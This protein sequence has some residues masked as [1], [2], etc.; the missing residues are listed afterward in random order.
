MHSL[1]AFHNPSSRIFMIREVGVE[2]SKCK[3]KWVDVLIEVWRNNE[4][5]QHATTETKVSLMGD[6]AIHYCLL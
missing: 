4:M 3:H 1:G 5:I 2:P 6:G